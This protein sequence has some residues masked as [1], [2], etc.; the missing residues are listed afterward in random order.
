MVD[1]DRSASGAAEPTDANRT[2]GLA[3]TLWLPQTPRAD[4]AGIVV[5]HGAGSRKENHHDYA[6]AAQAAGFAA[7]CFDQ[8][9]HGDSDGPMGAG[10][11]EDVAAIAEL[12]R[13]RIG[14]RPPIALR[15]SSMG[16]YLALVSARLLDAAAIV[17]ICPAGSER[18]RAGLAAQAYGFSADARAF[19][20]FLAAN[21]MFVA[22][23]VLS[24]PVLIL[25]AE[26]DESVP[27]AQS[28]ALSQRTRAPGSR[29]LV[30]AG[31]DHRSI[32]HD[33]KLQ[34]LSLRFIE[35]ALA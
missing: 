13:T 23:D 21:D 8:R 35:D 1:S 17:A 2:S 31:G 19:D 27:V 25:H 9:G 34:A 29:L 6:R 32:Q 5:V 20:A 28:R 33:S 24:A 30:V 3:Y 18:L 14:G 12:L 7:I 22:A 4:H 11:G 26:G 15:G 10:A 16:G